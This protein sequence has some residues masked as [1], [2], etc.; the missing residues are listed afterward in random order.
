M[1]GIMIRKIARG[2]WLARIVVMA[3]LTVALSVFGLGNQASATEGFRGLLI[4]PANQ[5]IELKNGQLYSGQMSVQN[6]TT[7]NMGVDMAVG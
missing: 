5:Q 6:T 7:E 3:I 4:S 1:R 2:E